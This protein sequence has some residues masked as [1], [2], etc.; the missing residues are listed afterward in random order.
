M[1]G[2]R[3]RSEV[4]FGSAHPDARPLLRESAEA[5]SALKIQGHPT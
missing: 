3:S 5:M 2:E 4:I 1:A